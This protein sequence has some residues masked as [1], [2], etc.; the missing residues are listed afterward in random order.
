MIQRTTQNLDKIFLDFSV[1][2]SV[3]WYLIGRTIFLKELSMKT[4]SIVSVILYILVLQAVICFAAED[5]VDLKLRLK[6]GE[7]HEMKMTQTQNITQTAGGQE[8]KI[9]QVQEMIMGLN[10]LSVDANSVMDVELIYKAMKLTMDG[11]MGHMEF[12]SATPKPADPNRPDEKILADMFSAMAGSKIQMKIKPTGETYDFRGLKAM[13]AK[14]KEKMGGGPEMQGFGEV[15]DEMFD[16]NQVKQIT[17]SM[18][19]VFPAQPV[20]VGDTWHSTT[21]VDFMVPIDINTTYMLKDR[22]DGIVYIDAVAKMDIGDGSKVIE[23]NQGDKMSVQ[24]SG[25]TNSTSRVDEKTGLAR[26]SN[27]VMNFSGIVKMGVSPQMPGG[28]AIPVTIAGN[29]VVELIK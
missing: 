6:A 29:A 19:C 1:T 25:T 15:F 16:E 13:T 11:P 20:A 8:Q 7:S 28:M 26:K 23:I 21:S 3:Q 14:L 24:I 10:V 2:K 9:K 5:K 4:K 12:D 17:G 22:K 27:M 18:L